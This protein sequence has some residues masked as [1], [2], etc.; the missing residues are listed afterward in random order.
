M[1]IDF[2]ASERHTLRAGD[3]NIKIVKNQI[4]FRGKKRDVDVTIKRKSKKEW[5]FDIKNIGSNMEEESQQLDDSLYNRAD[6]NIIPDSDVNL[7]PNVN[8][9]EGN[10]NV[11]FQSVEK[12]FDVNSHIKNIF[13]DS[14]DTVTDN[15]KADIQNILD[16]NNIAPEEFNIDDIRIYGSYSTGDN[17]KNSDLDFLVEYSGSMREDDAFNMFADSNLETSDKDGNIIKIDIKKLFN[18]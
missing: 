12:N 9:H 13:G 5:Y 18:S 1:N 3:E 4:Y 7:N 8:K 16:E 14:V 2:G 11:S 10:N 17:A 15:I 6:N